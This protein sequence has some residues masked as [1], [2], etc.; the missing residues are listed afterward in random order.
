M[1]RKK[2]NDLNLE[3]TDR[4]MKL[5]EET[6]MG[7]SAGTVDRKDASEMC[8]AAGKHGRLMVGSIMMQC[9]QQKLTMVG[10]KMLKTKEL[11]QGNVE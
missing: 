9:L 4:M 6:G 7:I 8:N 1:D 11:L 3:S 2:Q 10:G 5:M